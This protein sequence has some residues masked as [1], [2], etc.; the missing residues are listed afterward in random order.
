MTQEQFDALVDLMLVIAWRDTRRAK[1]ETPAGKLEDHPSF[2]Q[3]QELLV[4][5]ES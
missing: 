4:D 1:G 2:I 5:N 3:A